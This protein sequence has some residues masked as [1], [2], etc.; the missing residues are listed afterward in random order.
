[1]GIFNAKGEIIIYLDVDDYWGT[2]HLKIVNDNFKKNDWVIFNDW[3]YNKKADTWKE[4]PVRI[5]MGQCGT[6][7]VAHRRSLDVYWTNDSYLH[8]YVLLKAL[9]GVSNHFIQIPTAQYY[10]CHIPNA[11]DV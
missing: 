4:R 5:S 1:A 10:V 3:I 6:S 8:D 2:D 9:T 7:N 11:Y